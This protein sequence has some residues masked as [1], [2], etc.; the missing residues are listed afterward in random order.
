MLG[1]GLKI[2][3]K[4]KTSLLINSMESLDGVDTYSCDGEVDSENKSIGQA[5]IKFV[6]NSDYAG[7]FVIDIDCVEDLSKYTS[8]RF[9]FY[10]ANRS[11]I[12]TVSALFFTT[13]PF[14]YDTNFLKFITISENGWSTIDVLFADF[15]ATGEANWETVKG[16]RITINLLV[17]NASE[18]INLDKIEVI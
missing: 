10:T 6:K 8:L 15:V 1:L 16:L 3:N 4:I 18:S 17:D 7:Y 9:R 13:A 2:K 5:S 12:A 11:N 14:S